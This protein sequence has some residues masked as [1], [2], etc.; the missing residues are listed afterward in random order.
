MIMQAVVW[1]A[2]AIVGPGPVQDDD[3]IVALVK[4]RVADGSKPFVLIVKIKAK[5]G[6]GPA[7]EE[8]FGP[9]IA[10]T[11]KEKGCEVYALSRDATSPESLMLYERWSSVADLAAHLKAPHITKLLAALADLT[12]G[13]P[14]L[15]V[16]VPVGG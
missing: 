7:V 14:E 13:P 5:A 4:S 15:E 6:E 1:A 2:M 11:L 8:A 9:A 3:P 10:A 12:D 16:H